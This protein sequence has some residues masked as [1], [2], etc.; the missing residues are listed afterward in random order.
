MS[1][2]EIIVVKPVQPS[3]F[4]KV[5]NGFEKAQ[6]KVN[7]T[8]KNIQ[9]NPQVN[10][11]VK[12]IIDIAPF[13]IGLVGSYFAP[14]V[15]TGVCLVV[16][17]AATQ[18]PY[19]NKTLLSNK[20]FGNLTMGVGASIGITKIAIPFARVIGFAASAVALIIFGDHISKH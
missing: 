3:F 4:E 8:V 15:V 1:S 12:A 16:A 11:T 6:G 5:Q 7:V 13:I 19:D 20:V 10:K 18:V 17:F 2:P 9:Q 14:V